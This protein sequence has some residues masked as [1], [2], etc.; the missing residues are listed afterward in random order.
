MVTEKSSLS[1][2]I[3]LTV[4]VVLSSI[5]MM[6]ILYGYIFLMATLIPVAVS[7]LYI[8]LLLTKRQSP[9][10]NN[11]TI[12]TRLPFIF[13]PILIIPLIVTLMM[14]FLY[15]LEMYI[16]II[17]FGLAFSYM[18]IF[19][20]LPTAIY[21]RFVRVKRTETVESQYLLDSISYPLLT[22]IVPAYNEDSG[23]QRTLDSL[24]EADYPHKQII[25]VDDGSTDQTYEIASMYVNKSS[26][27]TILVIRKRNGGKSS[28][29]N[30]ALRFSKGEIVVIIDA[31]SIIEKNALKE[32]VN[33]F[34][35]H[36][37]VVAVAGRIKVLNRQNILTN[38][39]ALELLVGIHLLR[40]LFNLLG[41]IMIVPGA[42]GAFSKKAIIQRGLYTRDTLTEDFDLTVKLLKS[43][44]SVTAA[45]SMSYTDVP[46][47]LRGFYKQRIRW[48]RGNFQTLFK[49]NDVLMNARYTLL[50]KFGYPFTLMFSLITPFF[51]FIFTAFMITGIL[52]GRWTDIVIPFALFVLIQFFQAAI[53]IIMDKQESWKIILYTPI[54]ITVYK[55]IVNILIIK[56]LVDVVI[57]HR[58]SRTYMK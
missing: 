41:V 43:G 2:V 32:L 20:Y 5:A 18:N 16:L 44:G 49:H 22:I 14:A 11:K 40:P 12:I 17:S 33:E 26:R 25:V 53:V 28:A 15:S 35:Q 29:L 58:K 6:V 24:I 42:I 7:S 52:I 13:F 9:K 27:C 31:D 1:L 21:E 57:L 3:I 4:S 19:V 37:N 46:V 23:I 51:D 47:S 36:Y 38:C 30:Y 54:V 10:L 48:Y 34:Q 8:I 55:Q 45:D 50:H 39:V 56:G